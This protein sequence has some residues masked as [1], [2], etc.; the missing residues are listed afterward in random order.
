MSNRLYTNDSNKSEVRSDLGFDAD[1]QTEIRR[2]EVQ[3]AEV[4]GEL[5]GK[6]FNGIRAMFSNFGQAIARAR[7]AGELSAL[8]DKTL[9]DIGLNRSDIPGFVA[10]HI[11]LAR[12]SIAEYEHRTEIREAA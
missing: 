8:D 10:G 3:R 9:A 12:D 11:Q 1:W 5:I 2:A 6:A 7:T 4:L